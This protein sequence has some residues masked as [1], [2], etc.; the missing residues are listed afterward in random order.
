M[1]KIIVAALALALMAGSAYAAQWNFYGTAK[2]WTGWYDDDIIDR[3]ISEVFDDDDTQYSENLYSDSAIGANVIVSDELS[4]RFEY[5]AKNGVA[6]VVLLYGVWNFGSGTLTV[7]K[8]VTPISVTYSNQVVPSD[9]E[10]LGLGGFGD[11]D[12]EENAEIML[13]FGGFSIAFLDPGRDV[14]AWDG[15]RRDSDYDYQAVIPMIAAAYKYTFDMGEVQIAGGYN[16]VEINDEDVDS[17]AVGL[18]GKLNFGAVGVFATGV[19]GEN[20]GNLGAGTATLFEGQTVF[21]VDD[22]EVVDCESMGG[23][24]GLTF[25]VNDMLTLE[26][27]YGYIHDEYDYD[28]VDYED[29]AQSY[30]LQAAITL[31]PGVTITPE[32]GMIDQIESDQPETFYFG[33]AWAIAF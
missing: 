16:T 30:Y 26:A 5:G 21:L 32:V 14:D 12:N 10:Q 1:K 13:T 27:G 4:A 24:I 20:L 8:A 15:D 3:D 33:A 18:G 25:A 19:W 9:Y 29:E 28:N 23:T 6:D 2:V 22:S 31:A 17:Y 7:G 11:F